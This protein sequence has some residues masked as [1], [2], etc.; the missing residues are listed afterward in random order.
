VRVGGGVDGN[1]ASN[2]I[3]HE[4]HPTP[5]SRGENKRFFYRKTCKT[6]ECGCF[7]L[8]MYVLWYVVQ[9]CLYV[10]RV[11]YR[12]ENVYKTCSS[13]N[14]YGY[15]TKKLCNNNNTIQLRERQLCNKYGSVTKQLCNET[16]QLG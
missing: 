5:L 14:T 9:F 4:R 8:I 1:I 3:A 16:V 12:T 10:H 6:I 11:M 2:R 15:V 13:I 7:L